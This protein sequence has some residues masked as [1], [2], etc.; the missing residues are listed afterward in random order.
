M[1]A[2]GMEQT[3]EWAGQRPYWDIKE[4][5]EWDQKISDSAKESDSKSSLIE[6]RICRQ[7]GT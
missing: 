6:D 2:L 7:F 1:T 4:L 3:E 5:E